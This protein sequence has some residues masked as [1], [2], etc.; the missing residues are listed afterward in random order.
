MISQNKKIYK[1]YG[2]NTYIIDNELIYIKYLNIPKVKSNVIYNLITN[3]FKFYYKLK[4]KISF[5]YKI[6][7]SNETSLDIIVYYIGY[8]IS[9]KLIA[10]HIF[11]A[12]AVYLI[13]L[14]YVD[15]VNHIIQCKNY[16]MIFM[17]KENLYILFCE[18]K[19]LKLNSIYKNFHAKEFNVENFIYNFCISNSIDI[20]QVQNVIT[21]GLSIERLEIFK[22][23]YKD[24]SS[25]ID[26][27]KH[28]LNKCLEMK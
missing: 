24:I 1:L 16:I 22:D 19:I 12:K 10:S 15:Y 5:C 9:S 28:Y 23:K 6:L 7:K 20:D 13:Q 18:N 27:F 21:S 2:K 3:E 11:N 4:E 17:Y 26:I 25:K 8:D 14:C